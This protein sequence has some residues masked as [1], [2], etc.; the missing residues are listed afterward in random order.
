MHPSEIIIAAFYD[1][2]EKIAARRPDGFIQ[3]SDADH[4]LHGSSSHIKSRQTTPGGQ[5]A[6]IIKP[7]MVGDTSQAASTARFVGQTQGANA[8]WASRALQRRAQ[9]L[10]KQPTPPSHLNYPRG[11]KP[12]GL[13]ERA[14]NSVPKTPATPKTLGG[15]NLQQRLF[16]RQGSL[17]LGKVIASRGRVA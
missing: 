11:L 12:P 6:R 7:K 8:D 17:R 16:G 14:W 10:R 5:G 15:F 4:A 9:D 1:E 13:M 3:L 2:L